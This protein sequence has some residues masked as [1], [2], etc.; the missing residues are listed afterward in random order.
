MQPLAL[1]KQIAVDTRPTLQQASLPSSGR[2]EADSLAVAATQEL[3]SGAPIN[4][5]LP[6]EILIEI[7]KDVTDVGGIKLGSIEAED[8][9]TREICNALC[10]VMLV[11]KTWKDIVEHSGEFWNR[12]DL[13]FCSFAKKCMERSGGRRPLYVRGHLTDDG[14]VVRFRHPTFSDAF[15][16]HVPQIVSLYLVGYASY[17]ALFLTELNGLTAT[18]PFSQAQVLALDATDLFDFSGPIRMP[19]AMNFPVLHTL[20]LRDVYLD[21]QHNLPNV[22]TA[23][24]FYSQT[25]FNHFVSILRSLGRMPSLERLQLDCNYCSETENT[26]LVLPM[27][28]QLSNLST[29]TV[30]LGRRALELLYRVVD[31]PN[32]RSG[33]I[34]ADN[35][36]DHHD[37]TQDVAVYMRDVRNCICQL[38]L[39]LTGTRW[40]TFGMLSNDVPVVPGQNHLHPVS[41]P[42]A[43]C[44][45]LQ[46]AFT[47]HSF[48]EVRQFVL[49]FQSLGESVAPRITNLCL[50]VE[51][52]FSTRVTRVE[53][54][55]AFFASFPNLNHFTI[56]DIDVSSA[57]MTHLDYIAM[58]LW[59]S[60]SVCPDFQ[61]IFLSFAYDEDT[62][63]VDDDELVRRHTLDQLM[64]FVTHA[65]I[66][67]VLGI[68]KEVLVRLE[69]I[70][71]WKDLFFAF[72]A[73][74]LK[75]SCEL[76]L[77]DS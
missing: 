14:Q 58:G 16:H 44:H 36:A 62:I 7:L 61:S 29:L 47:A 33:C 30:R 2:K 25:D 32:V 17:I 66:R 49:Y 64:P 26:A 57:S 41:C 40:V 6:M 65:G 52:L 24:L 13:S 18:V 4:E 22:K 63:D 39:V 54:W 20:E 48:R 15:V 34:C 56:Q 11:C 35:L 59:S 67:V 3:I 31:M 1:A 42:P 28:Y 9:R 55:H 75:F 76:I 19:C 51:I 68:P 50:T 10:N 23:K 27:Q 45:C 8:H 72:K 46:H 69:K 37:L 74:A 70:E 71:A 60:Q 5:G 43:S 77:V 73:H 53:D 38:H 21:L 12:I